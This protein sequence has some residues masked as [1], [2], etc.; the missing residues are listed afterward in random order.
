MT[1]FISMLIAA[2]YAMLLQ[3]LVFSAAYGIT[4]SVKIAKRPKYLLMCALSV[5]FFS[6]SSS[7]LCRLLDNVKM[8]S[9]LSA[10]VHFLLYVAV[11]VLLYL[12][13]GAFCIGVLKANKKYMNSLGM[14]ALNSLV[15]AVPL[16]NASA[17]YSI[18]ESVGT[19]IG[20]ALAFVFA[21]L[22]INA[23]IR[24]IADNESIP[25]VFR[26]TPALLIYVSLLS[27]AFSCFTGES[28]F[29]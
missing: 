8:I 29:L 9:E 27:L 22:L 3:N 18:I 4:E 7:V 1:Q 2:L 12:I 10:T 26:G 28:L 17:N 20:A 11:T 23:G 19:G 5:G 24:H 16:L 6:V 14:C 13:S 25:K 15:L 21:V